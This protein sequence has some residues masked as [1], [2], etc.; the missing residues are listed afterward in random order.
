MQDRK[1]ALTAATLAVG[2]ALGGAA[3]AAQYINQSPTSSDGSIT[4]TFGDDGNIVTL[5]AAGD[6]IETFSFS[7]PSPGVWSG[8]VETSHTSADTFLKFTP[9]A[10]INGA[11]FSFFSID[12]QKF[13]MVPATGPATIVV[14]GTS[15]S[16]S[17]SFSGSLSFSPTVLPEPATWALM[18]G[19]FGL[20]ATAMRVHRRRGTMALLV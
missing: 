9:F 15:P 3:H 17:A 14:K 2:L 18:I 8:K 16:S 6:F 4:W 5:D 11:N 20:M 19:G 12:F 13:D 10:T 7:I 1:K